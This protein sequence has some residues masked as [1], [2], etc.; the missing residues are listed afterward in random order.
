MVVYH[1]VIDILVHD[2]SREGTVSGIF[3]V[4]YKAVS[5]LYA[6][7]LPELHH[8]YTCD[9]VEFMIFIYSLHIRRLRRIRHRSNFIFV[10]TT[11][12]SL[13]LYK[14]SAL[15]STQFAH[16]IISILSLSTPK[17][18]IHCRRSMQA[19]IMSADVV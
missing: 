1:Y 14:R 19:N 13:I 16:S 17:L 15:S 9:L 5:W 10:T 7:S 11:S 18:E 4:L 12:S 8:G 6:D 2:F 3:L